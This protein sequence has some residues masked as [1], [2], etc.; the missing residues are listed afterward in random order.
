M[1]TLLYGTG[2]AS[3]SLLLVLTVPIAVAQ[4][5][6]APGTPG[7]DRRSPEAPRRVVDTRRHSGR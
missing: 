4:R 1:R 5:A 2:L 6:G 3:A 7:T